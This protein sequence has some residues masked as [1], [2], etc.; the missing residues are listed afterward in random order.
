MNAGWINVKD[1]SANGTSAKGDGVTDDWE[2]INNAIDMLPPTGAVLF[3]PPGIY[4]S[5]GPVYIVNKSDFVV[6][7]Y[8]ATIQIDAKRPYARN[9]PNYDLSHFPAAYTAPG[10]SVLEI[11]NCA[12]FQ[13]LGL[14]LHGN[15]VAR[16]AALGENGAPKNFEWGHGIDLS[17]CHRFTV[18]S[19]E[20]EYCHCDGIE[21]NPMNDPMNAKDDQGNA[22]FP[23]AR[24]P[25][26]NCSEFGLRDVKVHNVARASIQVV[27]ARSGIIDS[28]IDYEIGTDED[29]SVSSNAGIHFEVDGGEDYAVCERITITNVLCRNHGINQGSLLHLSRKAPSISMTNFAFEQAKPP[30]PKAI[31]PAS[32]GWTIVDIGADHGPDTSL[33]SEPAIAHDITLSNGS[34]RIDRSVLPHL[35]SMGQSC[36]GIM[37]ETGFKPNDAPNPKTGAFDKA[38]RPQNPRPGDAIFVQ[39]DTD[40]ALKVLDKDGTSWVP[41]PTSGVNWTSP[42]NIAIHGVVIDGPD[43]GI[44]VAR[45]ASNIRIE[46]NVVRNTSKYSLWLLGQCTVVGNHLLD[47]VGDNKNG[48]RI[49]DRNGPEAS[50][51]IRVGDQASTWDGPLPITDTIS[52]ENNIMRY[53][54]TDAPPKGLIYF[55][56]DSKV[57][58]FSA[59]RNQCEGLFELDWNIFNGT[60][61]S[62]L[63][64]TFLG[65]AKFGNFGNDGFSGELRWERQ[66]LNGS[67]GN[68]NIT[69]FANLTLFPKNVEAAKLIRDHGLCVLSILPYRMILVT[70][71]DQFQGATGNEVFGYLL[72]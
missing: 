66:A 71:I 4:L 49:Y 29:H 59:N 5:S 56:L 8:G 19:V 62:F 33:P 12:D 61:R 3:F 26:S 38:R 10:F 65:N 15:Y 1:K 68:K 51:F 39:E 37:L 27:G 21:L 25:E 36:T 11:F 64:N 20:V 48:T 44:L 53:S 55:S 9:A 58:G 72:K 6:L 46:K 31:R 30:P 60:P 18:Q 24:M 13:V 70:T 17:G 67:I 32:N 35:Y 54:I 34:I 50:A 69:Q 7:G 57:T 14:R 2:A 45:N 63:E 23:G 41:F 40:P 42:Y 16:R 47:I 22:I 52:C 28:L 43:V